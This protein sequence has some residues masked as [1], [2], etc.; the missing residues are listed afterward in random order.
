MPTGGA[1]CGGACESKRT[2]SAAVGA[3]IAIDEGNCCSNRSAS[4][5]CENSAELPQDEAFQVVR[6]RNGHEDRV[7]APLHPL[8][9]HRDVCMRIDRG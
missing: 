6:F 3:F 8:L 5:Q 7:I 4:F 1:V 2:A 9:D